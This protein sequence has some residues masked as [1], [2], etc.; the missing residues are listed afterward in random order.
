MI[1]PDFTIVFFKGRGE[2]SIIIALKSF[3]LVMFSFRDILAQDC[4]IDQIWKIY[5]KYR[6]YTKFAV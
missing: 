5:I 4:S 2:Y 6:K 1:Q 3:V